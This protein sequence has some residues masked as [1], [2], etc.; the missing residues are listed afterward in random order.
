[1]ARD[2][3]LVLLD[4]KEPGGNGYLFPRGVLREP[5]QSLRRG[6]AVILTRTQLARQKLDS[7]LGSLLESMP[8]FASRHHPNIV[9]IVLA[10]NMPKEVPDNGV[11]SQDFD[12]L[13]GKKALAFSGI[14]ANEEFFETLREAGCR[15]VKVMPYRDHYRYRRSD[16]L[17]IRQT[18]AD[19]QVDLIVTTEKDYYRLPHATDW[20]RPLVVMGVEIVFQDEYFNDFLVGKV[21]F[22]LKNKRNLRT[23]INGSG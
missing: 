11:L 4:A 2:L 22:H 17:R 7:R 5:L 21:A 14:A 9:K 15:L 10:G 16:I 18:A 8:V 1:M 20:G 19:Q 12:F 6:H 13:K 3:D 23:T